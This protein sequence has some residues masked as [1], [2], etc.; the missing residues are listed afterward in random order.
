MIFH[1]LH[2]PISQE[3]HKSQ[4]TSRI[5]RPN[6]F[7]WSKAF[8][9]TCTDCGSNLCQS[10]RTY[11]S[12]NYFSNFLIY[13]NVTWWAIQTGKVCLIKVII[14]VLSMLSIDRVTDINLQL[15]ASSQILIFKFAICTCSA[16][17]I[18]NLLWL[19]GEKM[20]PSV[21]A[22]LRLV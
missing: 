18:Y 7:G 5:W 16:W 12:Y 15:T 13:A 8:E 9:I 10:A 14:F 21:C 4:K 11:L 19:C 1:F 3:F 6:C 22:E 2:P 20:L 17:F